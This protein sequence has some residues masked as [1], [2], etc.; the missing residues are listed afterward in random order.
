MRP[1]LSGVN[2]GSCCGVTLSAWG[3]GVF[4]FFGAFAE[5]LLDF[6]GH[7]GATLHV[8]ALLSSSFVVQ[9]SRADAEPVQ[10]GE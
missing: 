6:D 10:Q 4:L 1:A 5:R 9:V 2:L 8:V 7:E 3:S